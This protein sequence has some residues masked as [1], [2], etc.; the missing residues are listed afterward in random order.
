SYIPIRD[1]D[2]RIEAV[3]EVYDN[4]TATLHKMDARKYLILAI[5]GSL[6]ALLYLALL[7]IVLR[8]AKALRH[9]HDQILKAKVE[10]EDTNRQLVQRSWE[11]EA[12]QETLV[13]QERLATLGELT[14]TVSHELRNP[15]A[16]IRSSVHLAL[17][18]TKG[19][20]LGVD[21]S[22]E[23]VERNVVRCDDIISDLLGFASDPVCESRQVMGDDW[24]RATLSELE[25]S[26]NVELVENFAAPD[27]Q[28]VVAPERIRQAVVN[29]FE[30]A[31]QALADMPED[32]PRVLSVRTA[33]EADYYTIVFQDTGPGM[34]AESAAK[35]FEPLFS[36]KS[37]GCGLGLAT[38][39]K[40]IEKHDGVLEF[41][42][43][44][45][46]GTTV[47]ISLPIRQAHE[48][49]A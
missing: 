41:E 19:L 3:F 1:S 12:T 2:G 34:D 29:I 27:V 28:L 25:I 42:S 31:A 23:R 6:F 45:G 11:L 14:A 44:V 24:L 16:A 4:V 33:V 47:T 36:T 5:V 30:N 48:R 38:A 43:T 21:R 26:G 9:Q 22:L 46:L 39:N 13:Q 37:Y 40:I 35:A 7:L 18:K 15:L 20:E 32:K 49:A 10:L 8:A 17:Q